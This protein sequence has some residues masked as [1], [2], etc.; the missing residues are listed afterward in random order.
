MD[1]LS[2]EEIS[3][4][5][6]FEDLV[7]DYCGRP[8]L[9]ATT[10][11]LL[12]NYLRRFK[13]YNKRLLFFKKLTRFTPIPGYTKTLHQLQSGYGS[14]KAESR[15]Y[16]PGILHRV[17]CQLFLPHLARLVYDALWQ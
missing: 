7:A 5:Q 2:L 9:Q 11:F 15:Y 12:F 3:N 13:I 14:D 6:C 4:W 17:Q 1:T 8:N 16:L 10:S